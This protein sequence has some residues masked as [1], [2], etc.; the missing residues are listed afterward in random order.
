MTRICLGLLLLGLASAQAA[1]LPASIRQSGQLH[2][3]VNAIYPPMEYK[4]PATG[5]LKGLDIDLGEALARQMGVTVAWSES[6]F[7]QLLP[8]LD[9]GRADLVIS[10]LTDRVSRHEAADFIDYLKT[11]AQFY[12]PIASPAKQPTDLC[13]KA[14]GT[15]RSTSFPA[16]IKAWSAVHCEGAGLPAIKIVPAESTADARSQLKQQRIDAAVQGSETIPYAMANEPG[17]FRPLG[18]PFTTGY[19]GIAIKKGNAE[20]R[21]AVMAA[22][23]ALMQDGAYKAILAKYGLSGNAVDKPMLNDARE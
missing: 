3:S 19:Q 6:A 13:G 20:L 16:E 7:A 17:T 5:Q 8:S 12:V 18:A 21:D 11:G 9:T 14:V 4:D 23:G 10:G 1:E 2:A 15:S 22:L